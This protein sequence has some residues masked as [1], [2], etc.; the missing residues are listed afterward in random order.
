MNK[1]RNNNQAFSLVELIV[2]IAIMAVLVGI[3][4]PTLIHYID[5][6][7]RST[8]VKNAQ[9]YISALRT[10]AA[11]HEDLKAGTITLTKDQAAEV[12]PSDCKITE[13]LGNQGFKLAAMTLNSNAWGSSVVITVTVDE[14]G[15]PTF[16][17]QQNGTPKDPNDERYDFAAQLGLSH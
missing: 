11:E 16:T 2:V 17:V 8:D 7:K 9:E 6:S 13:A 15:Q 4:A 1:T 14:K 12:Q 5:K 10:Y 3:L